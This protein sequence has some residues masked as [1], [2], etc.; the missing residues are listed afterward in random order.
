MQCRPDGTSTSTY[1]CQAVQSAS[2]SG[3]DV[4]LGP[5][6]ILLR[7]SW[8]LT[9]QDAR[10][11][12]G[13]YGAAGR[14]RRT[15]AGPLRASV[16]RYAGF[17]RRRC[18]DAEDEAPRGR[19]ASF[20]D[21]LAPRGRRLRGERSPTM[22]GLLKR[23]VGR[24]KPCARCWRDPSPCWPP[25]RNDSL[26]ARLIEQAGF[27]VVYMTGFGSVGRRSLGRPY[28][29]LLSFRRDGRQ[30][31][32]HCPCGRRAGHRRCRQWLRQPDQRHPHGSAST[33]PPES[34]PSTSRIRWRRRS[35]GTCR[36]STVIRGQKD[37]RQKVSR[38]LEARRSED[39]LI[40]ARTDAR[41]VEVWTAP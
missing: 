27:E 40:I 29:G 20:D 22:A 10:A 18:G 3:S 17:I 5:C 28:L 30:R 38:R 8:T 31:T 12:Q 6:R 23:N 13:R 19:R 15:A 35:A 36:T 21:V 16:W 32:P 41:A 1:R 9:R 7:F 14:S 26:S 25:A 37:G 11:G 34:R 39:F 33:R 4:S 2:R 24:A